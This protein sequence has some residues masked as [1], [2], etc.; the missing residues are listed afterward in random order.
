MAAAALVVSPSYIAYYLMRHGGL[1]VSI[2]A[3]VALVMFVVGAFLIVTLLK[4]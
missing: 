2:A 1:S 3:I 4:E